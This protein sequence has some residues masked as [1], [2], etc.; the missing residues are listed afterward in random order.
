MGK[1]EFNV[2]L[3]LQEMQILWKNKREKRKCAN[4]P[5]NVYYYRILSQW[6]KF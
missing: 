6:T 4:A 2:K 1:N 3:S 5:P